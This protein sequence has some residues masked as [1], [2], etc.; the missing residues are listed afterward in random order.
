MEEKTPYYLW[1]ES[2]RG[3][4]TVK[5][6]E[7]WIP[8]RDYSFGAAGLP[9]DGS[10]GAFEIVIFD[11]PLDWSAYALAEKVTSRARVKTAKLDQVLGP[12]QPATIF[13]M[14]DIEI[15]QVRA[16]DQGFWF[17][18]RNAKFSIS[19]GYATH[20]AG[21]RASGRLTG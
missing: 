2:I 1:I 10:T 8:V 3:G 15:I 7:G 19:A 13:T 18:V 12:K 5:G 9:E 20:S 11:S 6:H 17:K 14:E 4:S 21:G 16:G